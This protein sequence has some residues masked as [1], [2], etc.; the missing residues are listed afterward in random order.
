MAAKNSTTTG[1]SVNL[2]VHGETDVTWIVTGVGTGI[3]AARVQHVRSAVVL[4]T[5][6]GSGVRDV[7]RGEFTALTGLLGVRSWRRRVY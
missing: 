5:R 6:I 7:V 3:I 1:R 2:S 4:A